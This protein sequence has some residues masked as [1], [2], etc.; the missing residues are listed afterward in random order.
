LASQVQNETGILMRMNSLG[1][2]SA[3]S[4][5]ERRRRGRPAMKLRGGSFKKNDGL[6]GLIR[7]TD[8]KPNKT[9]ETTKNGRLFTKTGCDW[10]AFKH[11]Q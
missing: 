5:Q 8:S 1:I 4:L 6:I 11:S 10:S 2:R 7:T 9:H 3:N